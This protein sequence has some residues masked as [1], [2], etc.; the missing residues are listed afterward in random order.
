MFSILVAEDDKFLNQMICA[1][2]EQEYFKAFPA[3]DGVEALR[4]LEKKHIDLFICD[5]MMPNINGYELTRMLRDANYTQP[6]LMVTAKSQLSD[7]EEGFSAGTD[8][9]LVKPF[10]MKEMMLR[11]NALLRRAKIANEKKMVVGEFQFDYQSFSI[12]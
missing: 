9:Y 4:I 3:F 5:I 8:D 12:R 7:I 2:L 6:I 11:V 1:K 10:H